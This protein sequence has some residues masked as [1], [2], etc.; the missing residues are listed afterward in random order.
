MWQF[1]KQT[2]KTKNKKEDS[3]D[4]DDDDDEEGIY[5]VEG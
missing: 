5:E 4:D 3:D 2:F 1:S